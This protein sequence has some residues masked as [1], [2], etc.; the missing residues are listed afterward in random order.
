M[1]G[2]QWRIQDF[3]RGRQLSE[4]VGMRQPIIL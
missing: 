4:G 2:I 3:P 1:G